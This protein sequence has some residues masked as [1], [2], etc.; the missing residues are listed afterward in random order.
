[1]SDVLFRG[2]MMVFTQ[3]NVAESIRIPYAWATTVAP[4]HPDGDL[5]REHYSGLFITTPPVTSATPT[6]DRVANLKAKRVTISDGTTGPC[7]A[8]PSL[9]KLMVDVKRLTEAG[10]T[11]PLEPRPVD[12]SFFSSGATMVEF[13]GG[14]LSADGTKLTGLIYTIPGHFAKNGI[15]DT[16][17]IPMLIQWTPSAG[18]T[19]TITV[20]D[21]P[22]A[23][24]TSQSI[25][26]AANQTACIY[27][28][29]GPP[30]AK[31][32]TPAAFMDLKPVGC[33]ADSKAVVDVDFKWIYEILTP[34]QGTWD[35]WRD[36]MKLPA[37][38]SLCGGLTDLNLVSQVSAGAVAKTAP[39]KDCLGGLWAR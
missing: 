5:A 1:M 30:S 4:R 3:G 15:G 31:R 17:Q 33:T 39:G 10:A 19:V 24:G 21:D 28:W 14:T 23:P 38:I 7:V 25:T 13:R 37:P 22:A 2:P 35:E 36:D 20:D 6:N 9:R 26:L 18:A 16:L 32:P 11:G 12:Q 34:V 29:D 8:D 27:Q